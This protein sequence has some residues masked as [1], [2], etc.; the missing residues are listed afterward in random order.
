MLTNALQSVDLEMKFLTVKN[1][2]AHR[3][4]MRQTSQML[5]VFSDEVIPVQPEKIKDLTEEEEEDEECEVYEDEDFVT[6]SSSFA[7]G[8]SET[9][10]QLIRHVLRRLVSQ[11]VTL[12]L[13][14]APFSCKWDGISSHRE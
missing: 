5:P 10:S 4:V 11:F 14:F 2:L 1:R 6:V 7:S 13:R 9:G 8:V 12:T 3:P